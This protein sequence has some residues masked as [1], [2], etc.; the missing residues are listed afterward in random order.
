V[1]PARLELT[2]D[3]LLA[4]RRAATYLDRRLP[5]GPESLRKAAWGGLTD[6]MPR[7]AVLSIHARV[8]GTRPD[9][10]DHE[11][12]VQVWGPRYSAYAVAAADRAPFTLGRLSDSPRK[13]AVSIDMADRLEAFLAG[14]RLDVREAGRGLGVHPNGLRYAAPTGR[15]LIHW[16]GARQPTVWTV[17]APDVTPEAARLELARRYLHVVGAGSAEGFG[18]WAGLVPAS[19]GRALA[20]LDAAGE[21]VPVRTTVGDAWALAADEAALRDAAPGPSAP[22]RL[23]PSGD[24]YYLLQGADRALLVPQPDRRARLWT[25]RVWPGAVLVDGEIVGTWRRANTRLD[26]QP[27][28]R[29]TPAERAAVEAEAATLPLLGLEG[30]IQLA[31][32][33]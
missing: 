18:E 30:R 16:D 4:Y 13:R 11:A 5:P 28:R 8:E 7:A 24:T 29:L 26:V 10:L 33:A 2:R 1:T 27:W 19:S 25:P 22:A 21:L 12:L 14:R 3:Q 15:V 6:S 20:D 17:P 23:L 31:W 9:V 32:E